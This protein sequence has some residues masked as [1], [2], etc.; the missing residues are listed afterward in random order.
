MIPKP[1]TKPTRRET[2]VA[3]ATLHAMGSN[4]PL[5]FWISLHPA[6]RV[7]MT[8]TAAVALTLFVLIHL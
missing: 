1:S 3:M 6:V 7:A 5:D 8:S 4:A 2:G